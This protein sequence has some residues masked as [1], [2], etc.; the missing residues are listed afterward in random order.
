MANILQAAQRAVDAVAEVTQGVRE[1]KASPEGLEAAGQALL[2][3]LDLEEGRTAEQLEADLFDAPLWVQWRCGSIAGCVSLAVQ[4]V[5]QC[6]VVERA[7]W[8]DTGSKAAAQFVAEGVREGGWHLLGLVL[9]HHLD[10][11]GWQT[12]LGVAEMAQL[13]WVTEDSQ[14]LGPE[15]AVLAEQLTALV[16]PKPPVKPVV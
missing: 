7:Q 16:A 3:W 5:L 9:H 12:V 4:L 6:M 14:P 2:V 8:A 11:Q 15:W 1:D 13:R 10:A